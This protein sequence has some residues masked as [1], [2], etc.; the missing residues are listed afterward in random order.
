[1]SWQGDLFRPMCGRSMAVQADFFPGQGA[2]DPEPD[3]RPDLEGQGLLFAEARRVGPVNRAAICAGCGATVPNT[4][5]NPHGY[6]HVGGKVYCDARCEARQTDHARI[7][8]RKALARLCDGGLLEED[9]CM[10][11]DWELC[12]GATPAAAVAELV[13][14][15]AITPEGA[16][17]VLREA[18]RA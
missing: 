9:A 4:W 18:E 12:R 10:A 6:V 16:A 2:R 13:K 15:R 14:Q 7:A 3:R 1:M 11:A 17:E 5:S 8:A